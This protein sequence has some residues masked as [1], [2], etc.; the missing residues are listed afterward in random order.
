[1]TP[2]SATSRPGGE[3]GCIDAVS[4]PAASCLDHPASS[5][6]MSAAARAEI[7]QAYRAKY[8]SFGRA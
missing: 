4:T 8:G 7:D 3:P 1:M 5:R 2:N 6:P